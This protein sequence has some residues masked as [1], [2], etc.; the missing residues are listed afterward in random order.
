MNFL[1]A[2][3]AKYPAV[4]TPG[5]ISLML[6]CSLVLAV[7]PAGVDAET[8]N[9]MEVPS[10]PF[11]IDVQGVWCFRRHLTSAVTAGNVLTIG[12]NNVTLDL[13]G[14][15]L[16]GLNAGPASTA[17]GIYAQD[18]K[19][20][21]IRN[22]IVR[23][24]RV[25]IEIHGDQSEGNLIE[26]VQAEQNIETGIHINGASNT[27]RRNRVIDTGCGESDGQTVSAAATGI[28]VGVASFTRIMGNDIARVRASRLS[29][30]SAS[31][32][33]I[34]LEDAAGTIVQGNRIT[35][36]RADAFAGRAYG[37]VS[38]RS[39]FVQHNRIAGVQH[40]GGN[41][42]GMYCDGGCLVR[43]NVIA[44]ISADPGDAYGYYFYDENGGYRD[45]VVGGI[46]SAA[47]A[48]SGGAD[49]GGNST[50]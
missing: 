47:A 41:A 24:F 10:V 27:V 7:V 18:R 28:R 12:V 34:S 17:T 31:A 37:I 11:T 14:F 20:L 23:G 15:K 19:N 26:Y 49:L 50:Y 21:V 5:A 13:N 8:M 1:P 22:G 42:Y 44:L 30:E 39:V 32:R 40:T 38:D 48:F 29:S 36:V 16:G 6:S 3:R 4:R 35:D 43:G 33:G 45:N 9:C 2:P 46:G 25:G